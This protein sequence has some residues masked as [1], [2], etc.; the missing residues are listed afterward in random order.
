MTK[1]TPLAAAALIV[2]TMASAQNNPSNTDATRQLDSAFQKLAA[3]GYSGIV[4]VDRGGAVL[5]EK[6]YGFANRATKTPFSTNT[7]V[8]IGSNTKDFTAVALLQLQERGKVS[9]R[10]SLSKFFPG[11]PA[12]KRSITIEQLMN[13]TAGFPIGLG[14]DF[15]ALSRDQLVERAMARPLLFPPGSNRQYS[16]T[17]FSLL[18]AV[19]ELA[20]G[21]TYDEYLRDN[22][23]LPAGMSHTGLLLPHFDARQIAHGYRNGEDLGDMLSKP[24]AADGPYWNLRGNGGMLS[25]VG[26]MHAFYTTLFETTKLLTPASRAVRFNPDE[27]VGLAGSDLVNSFLYERLPGRKLEIIVASNTA[28]FRERAAREVIAS[29]LGLPSPDG[30]PVAN[31]TQRKSATPPAPAVAVLVRAFVAA[32]NGGDVDK[33]AT[34]IGDHFLIE[35]GSAPAAQR[36]QRFMQTHTNLGAI[37]VVGLDQLADDVVEVSATSAVEGPLTLRLPVA[38]G[39]IRGV[40]VLVG[41]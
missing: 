13:H 27:P 26:D 19:I 22:I 6:G 32:L 8:Q 35:P 3:T 41:G 14:G 31:A 5:F 38:D 28:E 1:N 37:T 7:I 15:D 29:V 10:D 9:L 20:S 4:R 11:A 18:A 17:G 30:R 23:L 40:Q 2:A 39:K 36:A 16:N 24:H 33:L 25:T 12:D 21:Q 34:F